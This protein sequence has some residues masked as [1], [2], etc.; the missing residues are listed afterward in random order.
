M[1]PHG[2]QAAPLPRLGPLQ[3]AGPLW[4]LVEVA[5]GPMKEECLAFREEDGKV[6]GVYPPGLLTA[7]GWKNLSSLRYLKPLVS[8]ATR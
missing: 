6:A 5:V 1:R 3:G 2:Q 7:C 4:F 8:L